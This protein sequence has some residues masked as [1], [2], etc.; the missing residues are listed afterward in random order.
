MEF[1]RTPDDRFANLPGWDLE[2]LYTQV[3]AGDGSGVSLRLAHYEAGPTDAAETILL[4]HGEPSWSYLYRKMVPGLVAAG[5]RVVMPDLIGFGRSD[6][7]TSTDDYSYERHVAWIIE[8][9]DAHGFDK[10][11]FFGQ[12]WGGLVGLR[13]LTARQERFTRFVVSNTGL[14]L[15]N[16]NPTEAFRKWQEYS[17]SVPVFEVGKLVGGGCAIKPS[18]EVIAAYDAPFPDDSYKA[19]ARIFPSLYPDGADHPSNV[20]NK[21]AWEVLYGWTKP[22]LTCFSDGDAVTKGGERSFENHVPGAKGQK[23][24]IVQGGGHFV[25]EDKPDELVA[26]ITRFIADNP[27]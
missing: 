18:P 20:A 3:D 16:L 22:C 9:F 21:A 26:I 17:R 13:L 5:F 11:T 24:V 14:P 4:M 8:W 12:D 27:L 23:H 2:P 6:K 25:Q 7:P 1:V 19:G 15:A 10:V